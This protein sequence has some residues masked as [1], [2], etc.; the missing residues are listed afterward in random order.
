MSMHMHREVEDT[1]TFRIQSAALDLP[2]ASWGFFVDE[3][4]DSPENMIPPLEL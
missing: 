3:Q 1:P 2:A 4:G